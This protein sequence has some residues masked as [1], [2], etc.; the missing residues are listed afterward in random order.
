LLAI[1]VFLNSRLESL[2]TFLILQILDK[3]KQLKKIPK[4]LMKTRLKFEEITNILI[5]EKYR[6]VSFQNH[7]IRAFSVFLEDSLR[8]ISGT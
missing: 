7:S 8:F 5:F 2:Q 1:I 4:T 6:V 3:P